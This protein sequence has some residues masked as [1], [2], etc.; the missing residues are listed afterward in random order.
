MNW[1]NYV[2]IL[3]NNFAFKPNFWNKE[4][5]E[6]DLKVEV[7]NNAVCLPSFLDVK[8]RVMPVNIFNWKGEALQS[9]HHLR[10]EKHN[11]FKHQVNSNIDY[12]TDECVFIAGDTIFLGWLIPH[13]G[14]FLME[15]ISRLW[16]LGE[17]KSKNYK[18]LFNFYNDGD[19]FLEKKEWAVQLLLSFGVD[20]E[21][22]IFSSKNYQFERLYIPSQSMILHSNVNSK[23][24]SFIWN[25][26]KHHLIDKNNL[27]SVKKVYL[28]RSKLLRDKRKLINELDVENAF[29]K[30]GF[31]IIYPET[32]SLSQQVT[33]F[34]TVDVLAGPS[35]SALHN[36]AFLKNNAVVIS[37]TTTDFCLLNEVL[38]CYAAETRYQ[39]F[40]GISEGNNTW[41]IDI[42]KL[43]SVLLSHPEL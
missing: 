35:G 38:C 17:L 24:Q 39:L 22:I 26:I 8:S 32:L 12:D 9:S 29:K 16:V 1:S 33:L 43:Y 6:L 19:S 27:T 37:L 20:S 10:G 30:F 13:Y 25:K 34:S 7:I 2:S 14:H 41:S 5:Q 36:A 42:N 4:I 23:A 31:D 21:Q 28:S 40:F 11:F 18:F 15:S 3:N